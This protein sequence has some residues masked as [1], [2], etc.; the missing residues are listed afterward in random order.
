[1]K[2]DFQLPSLLCVFAALREFFSTGRSEQT[3][4]DEQRRFHSNAGVVMSNVCRWG[5]LGTANIARKNWKAMRL[6]GN[7]AITTVASRD[8]AKAQRFIDECQSEV[9]F[10]AVPAACTYEELLKRPDVDAVYIPLPTGIRKD[11]VVKT[12]EAGK[13]VL[14]EKPCGVNA[15]ELKAILDACR[16]NG[17]QFMDGVMFM[18][19][20]RLPLLRQTLDDGE[21]VGD[22]RRVTTQFCF[23]APE[24]F[25]K[26]NIR[27]SDS[28][29]PLGA[30]GDLGWYNLRF[31]LFAMKYRMPEKVSGRILFEHGSGAK[32]V[33]M[34]FSAEL[35]F[36]GGATGSFYCSF[37]TENHQWAHISGSKG[38]I[39][40][41]D[42]VLPFFGCES[43]F[44]ANRPIFSASGCTFRMESHPVRH[45]VREY[46]E[47]ADNAQEV[48]M[49]RT[50]SG[51]VLSKK[52]D[53]SWGEIAMKT[54][55]AMDACLRSAQQ[56]GKLIEV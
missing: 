27:V 18:H 21:A 24:E 16:A 31:T 12:A 11:W 42:F 56:G 4:E 7:S 26:S 29:E 20:A 28:L 13:H 48:N 17:V 51:L 49:I 39:H 46:S 25:M 47:G 10:S 36:P 30:L 22:I 52:L 9:P 41:P 6:A 19:S 34:E 23:S 44:E 1:V 8:P 38:S 50:F 37:R 35:F 55:T 43:A 45:A 53:A 3:P 54:Q 32:P 40:V 33:P 2:S 14:C 15:G 5:I